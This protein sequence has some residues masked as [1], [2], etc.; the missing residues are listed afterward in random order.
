MGAQLSSACCC[1]K[2]DETRITDIEGNAINLREEFDLFI[3]EEPLLNEPLL[4][5]SD[6]RP[7]PKKN[8]EKKAK[9]KSKM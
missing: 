3:E 2:R 9:Q 8:A 7:P 6:S 5:E 4:R 1:L